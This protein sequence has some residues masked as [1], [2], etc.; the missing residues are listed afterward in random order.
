MKCLACGAITPQG[1]FCSQCG[2]GFHARKCEGCGEELL[3]GELYC[4]GCGI[5]LGGRKAPTPVGLS[6]QPRRSI[7]WGFVGV[8]IVGIILLLAWPVYG[9]D[10]AASPERAPSPLTTGASSVDL[11]SMTPREAADRLFNRVMAAV[12]Q[13]DSTEVVQFLPMAIRAYELAEPLDLDG[14]FHLAVLRMEGARTQE[15]LSAAEDIL[16]A[17]PNH[18]LGLGVAADALLALGDT[19]RAQ[20]YY[21][22]WLE[23]YDDEI[24]RELPE[25]LTHALMLPNMEARAKAQIN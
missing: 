21:S 15:G 7:V 12:E 6:S 1:K 17:D 3:G 13:D 20:V 8:G 2:R 19:A 11:S 23:V 5:K 25:Y 9:P 18:L 14:S 16:A 22:R 24:A 4:T 10:E